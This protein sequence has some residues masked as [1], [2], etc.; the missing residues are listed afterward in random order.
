MST[1]IEPPEIPPPTP[2]TPTEPPREDPPGNPQPDIPPPIHEPGTP[3]RPE[4]LP[5][6]TPDEFPPRGPNGPVTPSPATDGAGTDRMRTAKPPP[7]Y[8]MNDG[9]FDRY[10][11]TNK[12]ESAFEHRHNPA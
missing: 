12:S 3:P 10:V 9:A 8:V 2:G 1:P 6:K 7:E 4:E 11:T 5:G